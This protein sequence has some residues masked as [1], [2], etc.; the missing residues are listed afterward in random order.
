M[1]TN[2]TTQPNKS[3]SVD[4]CIV[5]TSTVACDG[6][7]KDGHPRVYLDV[8]KTGKA[9]CPYCSRVFILKSANI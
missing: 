1:E 9:I 6:G 8:S 7:K 5:T 3:L 2:K 4:E